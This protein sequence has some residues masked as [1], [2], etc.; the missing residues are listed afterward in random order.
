[1]IRHRALGAAAGALA[2]TAAAVI[3][4]SPAFADSVRD[5]QWYLQSLHVAEAHAITTGNGVTVAVVDSGSYPHPDLKSNLLPGLDETDAAGGNGQNDTVGH[6]TEMAALIAAQGRGSNTGVQGIAPSAKILPVRITKTKISFDGTT[7]ALAKG[8]SWAT[9]QGAKVI[10]VSV[11][12]GPAFDL[13]DAVTAALDKDVVVVAAAGNA[14][15]DAVIGYPAAIDGVLAVGAS[16]RDGKHASGSLPDAKI[17]ICAPGVEIVSASPQDKYTSS[18]GTSSATAIVSGAAAL[19]RA[20]FPQLSAEDVVKR[21]TS[22]ADDIGPPGR[23][24]ECGFGRLNIVKALT[25]DVPTTGGGATSV[26]ASSTPSTAPGYI[27]P[28]A[29]TAAPQADSEP[30]SSSTPLVLGGVLVGLIV[31]GGL[32]AALVVRRRRG[33]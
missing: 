8:I 20:K 14:S 33:V 29:T 18:D 2:L 22:T 1:M 24:D 31:A 11:G 6:G 15:T 4:A 16:G 25:A 32:V 28:A 5:R 26:P 3:P 9:S 10:N 7:V 13:E 27:D 30:A 17:Q 19:V 23:D 21:L 12:A